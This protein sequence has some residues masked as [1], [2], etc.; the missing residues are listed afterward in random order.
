MA[1]TLNIS[2]SKPLQNRITAEQIE[3]ALLNN[4]VKVA[5]FRQ[6]KVVRMIGDALDTAAGKGLHAAV[7]SNR[8]REVVI[9][10]YPMSG[11]KYVTM[12]VSVS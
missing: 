6:F 4:R 11:G 5:N 12:R 8:R 7:F 2:I 9:N 1:A 3:S 10:A